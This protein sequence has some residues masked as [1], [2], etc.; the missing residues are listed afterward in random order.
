MTL[1]ILAMDRTTLAWRN[2]NHLYDARPP[3]IQRINYSARCGR[4]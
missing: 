4:L 1:A 3:F 2:I